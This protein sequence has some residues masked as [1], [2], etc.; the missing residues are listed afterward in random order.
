MFI[1][2]YLGW[3]NA[4]LGKLNVI[5][6]TFFYNGVLI[7]PACMLF[8]SWLFCL[9]FPEAPIFPRSVIL[10]AHHTLT[11]SMRTYCQL[12]AEKVI[13]ENNEHD[14][15][16]SN[17]SSNGR[18]HLQQTTWQFYFKLWDMEFHFIC[19]SSSITARTGSFYVL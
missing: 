18:H 9:N 7:L 6:L 19:Y 3:K 1:T 12:E 15:D 5:I 13:W 11:N 8:K 14:D 2:I 10:W 4:I 16:S 17:S